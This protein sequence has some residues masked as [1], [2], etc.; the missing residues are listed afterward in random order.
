LY[1]IIDLECSGSKFQKE[2]ITEIAIYL[3]D[4]KEVVDQFISLINPEQPIDIFV[5]KLTGITD[6]MV[7]TAPKFH[8]V[9]KRIIEITDKAILVGHNVPYDYK[10][11]KSAFDSLGFDFQI[12]TIDTLPISH[13]LLPDQ[14][15]YSLGKLCKSLGIP[16]IDRHRASGDALATV[17]L[18]KLLLEKDSTKEIIK[19]AIINEGKIKSV[20]DF[21]LMIKKIPHK[22]GVFY[23]F[24]LEGKIIYIGKSKNINT[25]IQKL[26]TDKFND[27]LLI[28]QHT[29]QIEFELTG[30]EMISILKENHEINKNNPNFNL[31][32]NQKQ[33]KFGLFVKNQHTEDEQYF[34][35]KI[36]IQTEIPFIKYKTPLEAKSALRFMEKFLTNDEF[37][38]KY[39]LDFKNDFL[40]IDKGRIKSEKSFI[41]IK[42]G[43]IIGYGFYQVYKQIEDWV[44]IKA[45]MTPINNNDSILEGIKGLF[46]RGK[47][48]KI[49]MVK[50]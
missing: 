33:K 46:F 11:L 25:K 41:A 42:N 28:Q 30:T 1:A 22:V 15:S 35:S 40:L 27:Y 5:Q 14:E 10:T 6:K 2:A 34:L 48:E 20:K 43:E 24:D 18:F 19:N 31:N 37:K 7:K 29:V 9:A 49:L 38:K 36:N 23:F 39:S 8:E 47:Y 32:K 16:L 50:K 44:N 21:D 26:L 12:N 45:L 3:F 4:G 17:S 13:K